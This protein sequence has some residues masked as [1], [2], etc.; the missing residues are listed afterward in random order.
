VRPAAGNPAA[1]NAIAGLLML[2]RAFPQRLVAQREHRWEQLRGEQA[3]ADLQGQ[4]ILIVGVGA[5]GTAVARFAQA[6]DMHVIG[7]RRSP[8]HRGEPVD[9]MHPPSKFAS[10][11]PRVQWLVLACPHTPETHHLLDA[12]ALALLP[13]GAGVINVAHGGLI[14]EAA[15]IEAL[16]SGCVGSTWLDAVERDPLPADSPLRTLSNVLLSPSFESS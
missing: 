2:A 13:R 11:L 4:T 3:P 16:Q 6:L 12:R 14:D 5:V 7:V 9:E 8:L 15:L 1:H 10:L